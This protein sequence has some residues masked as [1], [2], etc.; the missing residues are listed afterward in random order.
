M[1]AVPFAFPSIDD[2]LG[3]IVAGGIVTI[4]VIVWRVGV[5][6]ER[7]IGD[8]NTRLGENIQRLDGDRRV[9]DERVNSAMVNIDKIDNRLRDIER[10]AWQ[11]SPTRASRIR[12][13]TDE[14]EDKTS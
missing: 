3:W 9:L 12:E 6:I 10:L 8:I 14:E 5:R 11:S 7:R 13:R 4:L 1:A 2:F